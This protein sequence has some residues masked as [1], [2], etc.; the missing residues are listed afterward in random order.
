MCLRETMNRCR[1]LQKLTADLVDGYVLEIYDDLR[2]A[3]SGRVVGRLGTRNFPTICK[4]VDARV[5]IFLFEHM[6]HRSRRVDRR[7]W[8][9]SK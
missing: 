7:H 9:R 1:T 6:N 3:G 5:V 2:T 8:E 4:C